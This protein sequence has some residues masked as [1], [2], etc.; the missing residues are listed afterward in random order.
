VPSRVAVTE[1]YKTGGAGACGVRTKLPAEVERRIGDLNPGEV[2][3]LY[4][5]S[6]AAPSTGLG[7]SSIRV[8]A[9]PEP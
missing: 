5:I 9:R 8:L 2:S 6:S 1:N 7:E 4:R 3:D